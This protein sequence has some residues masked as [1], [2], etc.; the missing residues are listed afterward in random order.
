MVKSDEIL[1]VLENVVCP[2][3]GEKPYIDREPNRFDTPKSFT[4]KKNSLLTCKDFNTVLNEKYA[5]TLSGSLS[6]TQLRQWVS[7][8]PSGH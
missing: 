4:G 6:I 3:C 5:S 8:L 7:E 1:K 2:Y